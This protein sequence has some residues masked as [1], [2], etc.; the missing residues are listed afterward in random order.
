[1][2]VASAHDVP[3][4]R[5][6]I[7]IH[8]RE[9]ST[10]TDLLTG[11]GCA[12][13]G[14]D[15]GGSGSARRCP[16][17]ERL[18]RVTLFFVIS[19]Y[20][21]TRLLLQEHAGSGQIDLRRFYR[22]RLARLGPALV[23]VV[24]VSWAWLAATNQAFSSYWAVIL[25]SLTYTTD[26]MQAISGNSGVSDYYQWSW[27][28][29]V[30]ELLY[31][32][33][34]VTLLLLVKWRRFAPI[35]VVLLTGIVLVRFPSSRVT[36]IIGRSVGPLGAGVCGTS[37][38]DGRRPRRLGRLPLLALCRDSAEKTMGGRPDPRQGGHNAWLSRS[39][40]GEPEPRVEQRKPLFETVGKRGNNM[41][42]VRYFE[43]RD[44]HTRCLRRGHGPRTPGM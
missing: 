6:Y 39:R 14:G 7:P 36:R 40:G 37:V 20:L 4:R 24:V 12:A 42:A 26:L 33:W 43:I 29:G 13:D 18:P 17:S 34:P 32:I 23:V 21:I 41:T 8:R 3:P 1:M 15:P 27:S 16:G 10:G 30:E 2:R 25:G 9:P 19:G 28:L 22:R 35:A 38:L 5:Q 31:L 11:T 44:A